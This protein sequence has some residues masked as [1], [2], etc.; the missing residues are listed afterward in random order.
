LL[1]CRAPL[2]T[3]VGSGNFRDSGLNTTIA[4][5]RVHSSGD[6]VL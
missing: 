1:C 3:F 6:G 5:S 4:K 2:Q